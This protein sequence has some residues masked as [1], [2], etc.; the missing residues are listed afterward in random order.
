M[1]IRTRLRVRRQQPVNDAKHMDYFVATT[2]FRDVPRRGRFDGS[3]ISQLSKFR[4]DLLGTR[5][6]IILS[7]LTE[8]STTPVHESSFE[9]A[10]RKCQCLFDP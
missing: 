10:Q 8:V 5:E 4:P 7:Y 2:L 6:I 1:T 9:L 3:R